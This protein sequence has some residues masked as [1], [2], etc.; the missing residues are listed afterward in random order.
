MAVV[1]DIALKGCIDG[2]AAKSGCCFYKW[3]ADFPGPMGAS[4]QLSVTP[5]LGHLAPSSG[6]YGQCKH[7]CVHTL[8]H[9]YTH[10]NKISK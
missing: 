6:L 5:S 1:E 3:L 10:T 8:S 9:N 4:L 7:T 2:S